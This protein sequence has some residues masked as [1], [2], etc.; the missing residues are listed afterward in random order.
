MNDKR[1]SHVPGPG[2]FETPAKDKQQ[3]PYWSMPKNDRF[4]GK[5][6]KQPGPGEYKHAI[7]TDAGPK[8]TTRVKPYIDPFKMKTDPGPGQ[9]Q[10]EKARNDVHYSMRKKLH[11]STGRMTPGPG[12]YEDERVL[13]YKSIPGSKMGKDFRKS[14]HFLHTASYLKQNP[15]QYN[16]HNFANNELMGVPKY[17]FSRDGRMKDLKKGPPGPGNY[18]IKTRMADGVPRYSMPGRRKDLRPKVG[19]GVPGSGSYEPTQNYV[20]KNGPQFSVGK[21][22]RDGEIGIFKNTPGAG[23]YHDISSNVVRA[24]S[25]SWR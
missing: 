25:A 18:E 17:S 4:K 12:S 21:M 1:L 14:D 16:Q 5:E 11:Q 23:T 10:P 13:H 3:A 6:M 2:K 7:F 9:Y 15:G 8:F 19:V 22:R 24:K 20:K